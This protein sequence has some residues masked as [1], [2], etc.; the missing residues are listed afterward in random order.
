MDYFAERRAELATELM[1]SLE[2]LEHESGIF[3]IKPMFSYR[4][5]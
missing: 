2:E 3:M 1:N 5:L 4:A